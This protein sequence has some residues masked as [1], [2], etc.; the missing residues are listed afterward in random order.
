MKTFFSKLDERK[1]WR[2]GTQYKSLAG[3]RRNLGI[4]WSEPNHFLLPEPNPLSFGRSLP[5]FLFRKSARNVT[6]L[7][8]I[9]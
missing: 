3:G 4:F 1:P 2:Q 7:Y 8:K 5:T 9:A 6:F